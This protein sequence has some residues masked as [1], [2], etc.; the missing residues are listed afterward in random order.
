MTDFVRWINSEGGESKVW[1]V[2]WVAQALN[3]VKLESEALL[4]ALTGSHGC[5]PQP[6]QVFEAAHSHN[7]CSQALV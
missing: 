4:Q 6:E 3:E 5:L 1:E 2:N 7:K